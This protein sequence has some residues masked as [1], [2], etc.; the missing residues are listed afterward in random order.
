MRSERS[1]NPYC[2]TIRQ[3]SL[4][5]SSRSSAAPV[6][7]EPGPKTSASAARPPNRAHSRLSGGDR[8]RERRRLRHRA[9]QKRSR[10]WKRTVPPPLQRWRA[11]AGSC[12]YPAARRAVRH[13]ALWR[14]ARCIWW[15]AQ[16]VDDIRHFLLHF[17]DSR[18]IAEPDL[19]FTGCELLGRRATHRGQVG[20]TRGIARAVI[21]VP[22]GGDEEQHGQCG[23][24]PAD[25]PA[26]RGSRQ[27]LPG[28]AGADPRGIYLAGAGDFGARYAGRGA[29]AHRRLADAPDAR[30]ALSVRSSLHIQ[31]AGGSTSGTGCAHRDTGRPEGRDN[32]APV[33]GGQRTPGRKSF[34]TSTT[35]STS[36]GRGSSKAAGG[37]P[38]LLV[39]RSCWPFPL[40]QEANQRATLRP[41]STCQTCGPCCR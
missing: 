41:I 6:V 31:P 7:T 3:A 4:F 22:P 8:A 30:S 40:R 20:T 34:C 15:V 18:D 11:R 38:R 2:A 25:Q 36:P 39:L 24:E 9:P 13:V 14:R 26:Y 10:S 23:I 33:T 29:S 12:P 1:Q 16:I 21:E 17:I 27:E 28:G 5:A 37:R 35:I 32:L 19:H